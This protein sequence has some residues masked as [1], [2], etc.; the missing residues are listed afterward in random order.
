M[1]VGTSSLALLLAAAEAIGKMGNKTAIHIQSS[2][3]TG[4]VLSAVKAE[5]TELIQQSHDH[6][7]KRID[8]LVMDLAKKTFVDALEN[9]LLGCEQIV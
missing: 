5:A 9:C 8:E 6:V 3:K 1:S 4:S 7:L 2:K